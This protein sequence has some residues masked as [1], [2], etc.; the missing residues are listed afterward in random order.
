M[1]TAPQ[2]GDTASGDMFPQIAQKLADDANF[3]FN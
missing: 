3:L 1:H 2:D